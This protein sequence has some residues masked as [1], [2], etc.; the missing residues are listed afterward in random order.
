MPVQTTTK[1]AEVQ[2]VA[3]VT[4]RML[5]LV[6]HQD[7]EGRHQDMEERHQDMEER[8]QDMEERHQDMEEH[9]QDMEEHHQDK[10]FRLVNGYHPAKDIRLTMTTD[11]HACGDR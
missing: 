11:E 10:R 5:L 6:V 9:H 8:H 2:M 1:V 3:L 7:M 4:T